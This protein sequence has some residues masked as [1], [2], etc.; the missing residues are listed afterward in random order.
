RN[1]FSACAE[2]LNAYIPA[3]VGGNMTKEEYLKEWKPEDLPDAC[4]LMDFGEC[5]DSV[6]AALAEKVYEKPKIQAW[7]PEVIAV[8]LRRLN[9]RK[10]PETYDDLLRE[11]YLG[12]ICLIGNVK[13][14]D[15]LT[16]LYVLRK[17]GLEGLNSFVRNVASFAPPS[18]TLRHVGHSSN[19]YG[20]IFLMPPLFAQICL[21]KAAA[22]VIIPKTGA[23]AE[24]MLLYQKPG[25]PA[26]EKIRTFFE[27]TAFRDLMAD[28]QMPVFGDHRFRIDES[29]GKL[30]TEE[31][32]TIVFQTFRNH[33]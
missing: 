22:K 28:Y 16:G 3:Q 10:I 27:S 30:A 31:E 17:H 20:S 26:K 24:P 15:P 2:E 5:S 12:E 11:D 32:L 6:F 8:D 25:A 13:M 7:F 23:L 21:E 29:C 19:S 33:S 1:V 14:P 18:E 4:F 9:G